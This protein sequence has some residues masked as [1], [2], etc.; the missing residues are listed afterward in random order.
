VH[1][2][3][4]VVNSSSVANN[5]GPHIT[6]DVSVLATDDREPTC[7]EEPQVFASL[8][9]D[10]DPADEDYAHLD[11]LGHT[12]LAARKVAAEE[13]AVDVCMGCPL[14]LACEEMDAEMSARPGSVFVHGVIGG[15]TEDERLARLGRRRT[16]ATVAPANPQIAPGD[17]GPRKQVDDDLVARLTLA[18]KTGDQIAHDLQCSVR[19]VTRARKRMAATLTSVVEH[20][21]AATLP[22]TAPA[23]PAM[24]T[25]TAAISTAATMAMVRPAD[26]QASVHPITGQ[27]TTKTV[28][29]RSTRTAVGTSRAVESRHPFLNGRP[30]SAAM[31]AVYDHLSRNEGAAFAD[32]KDLAAVHIDDQEAMEWWLN[33]NSTVENGTRVIRPS[34]VALSE[35]DRIREGALAKAHNSV[36]AAVRAGRY[37]SKQGDTVSLLPAA[38]EAWRLRMAN[39]TAAA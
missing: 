37:L 9:L 7:W 25:S 29:A 23:T 4:F 33:R 30:I 8:D 22:T 35:A 26:V 6:M 32:L 31:E 1:W 39:A 18:G 36:D 17:R 3:I 2:R 38:L 15:R 10:Y 14:M 34:K 5:E 16:A 27:R 21:P 28:K 11:L 19:T 20:K 13:A 12:I 24:S